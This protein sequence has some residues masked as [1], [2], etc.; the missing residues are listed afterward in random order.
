MDNNGLPISTPIL[1]ASRLLRAFKPRS[2][3]ADNIVADLFSFPQHRKSASTS[4]AVSTA[5]FSSSWSSAAEVGLELA[6]YPSSSSTRRNSQSSDDEEPVK[7]RP[8]N[9]KRGTSPSPS[10]RST[11]SRA[12]SFGS[13][14]SDVDEL[15]RRAKAISGCGT[16]IRRDSAS[17]GLWREYWG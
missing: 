6:P 14:Y 7:R 2:A 17:K 15:N 12:S 11:L 9:D 5:T 8:I 3:S 1:N 4:S 10:I 16:K 13:D